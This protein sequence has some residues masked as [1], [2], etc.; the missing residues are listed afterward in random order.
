VLAALML[1]GAVRAEPLPS[2]NLRGVSPP[3]GPKGML[4]LESVNSPGH[5]QFNTAGWLSWAYRPLVVRQQGQIVASLV[6]QQTALD[7]AGAVGLGKRLELGL[8]LP[9]VLAQSGDRTPETDQVLGGSKIPSQAIGDTTLALKATLRPV[10]E[11][12]GGFGL[13]LVGR[14]GVPTGS[15]TSTLG[16]GALTSEVRALAELRVLAA[17]LLATTGFKARSEERAFGGKIWGD[18]IPWGF[19]F[20]IKPQMLGLDRQGRWRVGI[21]THGMLPA[22]P[23][24]PFTSKA[25]APVFLAGSARYTIRDLQ[26]LAGLEGGISQGAGAAPLRVVLGANWAPRDHDLDGDGIEDDLD[27]CKNKPEDRDGFEDKDGCP[28]PDNDEDDVLDEDDKCPLEPEDQDGFE[29]EDGCPDPDN[30]RD[31]ILDEQDACPNEAGPP[32]PDPEKNGCPNLDPDGDGVEGEADRCPDQPEDF[33]DFEDED[34]CPDPDNDQDG[35]ADAEDKCPDDKGE[36]SAMPEL[37]GCP[38]PDRDNDAIPN[39][40]DK[41]P[42]EPETYNGFEDEDGCPDTPRGKPASPVTVAERQGKK[43]ITLAAPLRFRK[44][45]ADLDPRSLTT[46]RALAQQLLLAPKLRLTVAVRPSP[47]DGG[48]ELARSRSEALVSLLIRGSRRPN[49]AVV[50]GW[51]RGKMPPDAEVKGVALIVSEEKAP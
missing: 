8:V 25:Q 48:E 28:D 17:S 37:H 30:D 7:L 11:E 36:P 45:S 24:A 21:E 10:D 29:D 19:G 33:D 38:S 41:C 26:L 20:W 39:D 18:E 47:A 6:K 3:P 1:A 14:V 2:I 34:G 23:D 9:V 5:L 15:R 31:G 32:H 16:E 35:I 50:G 42:D 12:F 4:Y 43:T 46:A 44:G 13:A 49:A 40:V 27:E 51:T 22:G